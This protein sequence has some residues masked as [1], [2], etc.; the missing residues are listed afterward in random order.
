MNGYNKEFECAKYTLGLHE[1]DTHRSQDNRKHKLNLEAHNDEDQ[2]HH[3]KRLRKEHV[4]IE[5]K[6][7]NPDRLHGIR[8][9]KCSKIAYTVP[10]KSS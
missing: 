2:T 9:G 8:Y 6:I 4:K 3:T 5:E 1:M 7:G 10:I